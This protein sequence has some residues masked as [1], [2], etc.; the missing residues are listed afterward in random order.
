[1]I[2]WNIENLDRK[3]ENGYVTTIHWRAILQ[4]DDKVVFNYGTVSFEDG[5][6]IIA[7]E[8]LTKEIILSWLFKKINKQ[9]TESKLI[10]QFEKLKNPVIK[11]GL[12]WSKVTDLEN[13]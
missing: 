3:S 13:N 7:F 11:S 8:N 9:E 1:M 10:E 12:P 5:E 6:P 4:E 2:K